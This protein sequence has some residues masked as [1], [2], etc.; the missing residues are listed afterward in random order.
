MHSE[1]PQDPENLN[2]EKK[3][4]ASY[5]KYSGIVFQMIAVIGLL[6]FIGYKLDMWLH[7]DVKWITALTCVTGVCLS[8]FI[9]I[10]QL[11]S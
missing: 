9:T 2:D 7:H 3:A 4:L 5:A 8:I 10:K 6:A 11:K 1:E